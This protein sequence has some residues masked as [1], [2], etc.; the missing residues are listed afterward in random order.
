MSVILIL[1]SA[2]NATSS[3]NWPK[4]LFSNILTINNAWLVRPDWDAAIYA[5]DFPPENRPHPCKEQELI[6]EETFVPIQNEYGGFVYSGGTMAFT[7]GYFALGHYKPKVLAFLGCDMVY[8][9]SKNTHFYGNGS[10]DPLRDDITLR[11]LE[12]KSMRLQ[13]LA[14]Q[15]GCSVVNLSKEPSRLTFP[16]VEL[17]SVHESSLAKFDEEAVGFALMQEKSVG[18]YVPSGRYWKE[19]DR[20]DIKKIDAIDALWRQAWNSSASR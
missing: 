9:N 12:A 3:R 8:D 10:P 1:G 2:P 5:W 4:A 14:A 7:A 18:Y 20:F 19:K 13:I 16:R 11:D 15:Q 6:E 17:N